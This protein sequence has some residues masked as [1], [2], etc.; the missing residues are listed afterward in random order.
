MS[1]SGMDG[2]FSISL[3]SSL[4]ERKLL[5]ELKVSLHP[6]A[7]EVLIVE[8]EASSSPPSEV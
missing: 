4:P 2:L 3:A 1:T 8:L 5:H 7:Q 6:F